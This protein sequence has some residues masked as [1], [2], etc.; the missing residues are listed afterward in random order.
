MQAGKGGLSGARPG[1]GVRAESRHGSPKRAGR[2]RGRSRSRRGTG[3]VSTSTPTHSF[4]PVPRAPHPPGPSQGGGR[5]ATPPGSSP[6]PR[7]QPPRRLTF[8]L[9]LG[10]LLTAGCAGSPARIRAFSPLSFLPQ[11]SLPSLLRSPPARACWLSSLPPLPSSLPAT[12]PL[13]LHLLPSLPTARVRLPIRRV[14][15]RSSC[16]RRAA[17]SA[18][19]A[20]PAPLLSPLPRSSCPRP[21]GSGSLS[22]SPGLAGGGGGGGRHTRALLYY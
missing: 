17:E 4:L 2:P 19:R 14:P 5:F 6:V 18:P 3:P 15:L 11:R 10:S 9:Y 21:V 22:S 8:W 1:S 13:F 7:P 20:P 12:P 16:Q